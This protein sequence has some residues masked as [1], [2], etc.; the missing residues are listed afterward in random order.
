MS[1]VTDIPLGHL[2]KLVSEVRE[3]DYTRESWQ[4]WYNRNGSGQLL[5]QASTAACILNEMI[6]GLSDQAVDKLTRM[7]KKPGINGEQV[8]AP[9]ARGASSQPNAV[10]HPE[11]TQSI[12]TVSQEK[13]ARSHLIDSIGR[14]LHEYLS[15]EI[16]RLPIDHKSSSIEPDGEVEEI[17]LHFFQ[18]TAMLHQ[19]CHVYPAVECVLFSESCI[20]WSL[21]WMAYYRAPILAFAF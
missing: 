3:K 4:S 12:W 14:I 13:A 17:T 11:L 19:V 1:V 18:D 5:R 6:F 21:L 7:F 16:W 10:E 2:R 15:S 9:Y 20:S 8:R